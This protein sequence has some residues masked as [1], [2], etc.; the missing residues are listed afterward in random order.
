MKDI[1]LKILFLCLLFYSH[2]FTQ[3]EIDEE[4]K[5]FYRDEKTIAGF[6]STTGIG[7]NLSYAKRI[8]GYKKVLY[9]IDIAEIKHPKEL[10]L[11]NHT[12]LFNSG[13]SYVYGK[14]NKFF[15]LRTGIGKQKEMYRKIDKGGVSIRNGISG[16]L[17]LGFEKPVYYVMLE[18][19]PS[20]EPQSVEK[21]FDP[22]PH[23]S[24]QIERNAS[25]FKGFDELKLVPGVYAKYSYMFEYGKMDEIIHAIEGGI[26]VDL[27]PRSI[28]IMAHDNN[29]FVFVSLYIGYRF[30]KVVDS[31]FKTRRNK[32]DQLLSE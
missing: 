8:D 19:T 1:R 27:F 31:R 15:V 26:I 6:L 28:K 13:G 17:S 4:Q 7:L 16:G 11:S 21:K 22:G 23:A 10:K 32:I 14:L 24:N 2:A 29:D 20:L 25:F 9:H 3:G 12:S 18:Y 5:I 30:G